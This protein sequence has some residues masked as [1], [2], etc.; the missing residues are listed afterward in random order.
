M[1]KAICFILLLVC[2]VSSYSQETDNPLVKNLQLIKAQQG[3]SIAR[4]YLEAKKDS[5]EQIGETPSYILL[6]GLLTSNM[7]NA[8]P[9]E[10][11][12][13]EYKEYLDAVI[14]DEIKS[15]GYMPDFELLSSLW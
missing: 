8:Y 9:T 1:K 4:S 14:D 6:W 10:S 3:D 11:L 5:L 15:D 13:H 12:K 7:W 2:A